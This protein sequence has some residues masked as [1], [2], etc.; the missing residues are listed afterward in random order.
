MKPIISLFFALTLSTHLLTG[1]QAGAAEST[2]QN[3][4][5]SL[6]PMPAS[7]QALGNQRSFGKITL[8]ADD[9]RLQNTLETCRGMLPPVVD[10]QS[11]KLEVLFQWSGPADKPEAYQ[12]EVPA[13]GPAII[14]ASAPAGAFYGFQS[15]LQLARNG[16]IPTCRIQD[17][18]RFGWR[19]LMLDEARHFMGKQYVKQLLRTMAAHKLNKFHW[20]LTDNEGW[21]IEIKKYPYLT[22]TAGWR[23]PGT[24]GDVPKWDRNT[25][26]E[27]KKYGGFYTQEDIA[28][29]VAYAQSLHIEVMPEIDVPGHSKALARA[30]PQVLP[31]QDSEGGKG[32]HGI[33]GNVISVVN[34]DN[35][36]ML[37][38]IFGEIAPL[39]PSPYIH[40]GGDEVN[41]NAW[42]ASPE[43]R[44]FMQ[45]NGMKNPHQLQNMFML[46]LEKMLKSH[47]KTLMGW[48]EIMHGGQ[49]SKDTGVMAWI[50][51]GAGI[52][53]AKHGYPTIMAVGPHCYFD[54]KYPGK[55][56]TGHWW[57]GIVDTQKAY[58]WNPLFADQLDPK[59]QKNI[60]GVH[61]A[62]WT[63]FVPDTADADYK[64]WPRACA[65]AEVGWSQQEYRNW[66]QFSQRLN[67]HLDYLDTL[68]V[69]YRVKPPQAV[70]RQGAITIKPAYNGPSDIAYTLD[71][72]EPEASGKRYQGEV[73]DPKQSQKLSYRTI[74]PN[75]RM[76]KVVS[77]V[78]RE[79]IGSWTPRDLAQGKTTLRFDVSDS[80]THPGNWILEC[81][82]ARGKNGVRIHHARLLENDKPLVIAEGQLLRQKQSSARLRLPVKQIRPD[83]TYTI[84]LCLEG[85]GSKHSN[86][87]ITF[88]RSIWREPQT[89][90]ETTVPHHGNNKPQNAANWKRSDW[91]WSN[92]N[93]KKGDRWTYT[94]DHAISTSSIHIPS[95]KPNSNDDIIVDATIEISSDGKTFKP[96]GS[97]S[98]GTGKVHFDQQ[99]KIKALR[100]TLSADHHSWII[101]R[102]L[103]IK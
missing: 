9:K 17:A 94:F 37:D 34:E 73:F 90:V 27:K 98:Y 42:K 49:L 101:L 102:D 6:I 62:L 46:R 64:L 2:G 54:M 47:G 3:A 8:R 74:R 22:A 77:G 32:V 19:G 91:F 13:S 12:L 52:N 58:E 72:S 48:N 31:K 87:S 93:G 66:D 29:I 4:T 30:Y 89:Q 103:E 78:V 63:E 53:A 1:N 68:N 82:Y 61:C 95:G 50:S 24:N 35:Y 33:A 67:Q 83:A 57:A 51:I 41:V 84:E 7:Y 15:L 97:F 79:P 60:L 76:S 14:S 88:D 10:T 80:L 16:K 86:G 38:D 71:G 11:A 100:V 39:F 28:E 45:K 20:H 55:G 81:L 21:R 26:L 56:E 70:T 23:G 85:D 44:D 25:P 92:R 40:V 96:A 18:P 36:R 75:G 65:T 59:Q 5:P 43:H 99:Q 69:G